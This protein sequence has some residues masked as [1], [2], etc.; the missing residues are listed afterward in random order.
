MGEN[1]IYN[2]FDMFAYLYHIDFILFIF[3]GQKNAIQLFV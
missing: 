1:V 2:F 3:Q